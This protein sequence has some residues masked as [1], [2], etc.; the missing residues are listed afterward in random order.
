MVR[1]REASLLSLRLT[2]R[3]RLLRLRHLWVGMSMSFLPSALSHLR[4]PDSSD[5]RVTM[6]A[7]RYHSLPTS[8]LEETLS[9]DRLIQEYASLNN[10]ITISTHNSKCL[11]L[12]WT[13]VHL[14]HSMLR[15]YHISQRFWIPAK[16]IDLH[17][18]LLQMA[19]AGHRSTAL[20]VSD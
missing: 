1:T 9:P 13:T 18:P 17:Q 12:R 7:N 8:L 15:L 4:P 5:R 14:A 6:V 19:S 3:L 10:S 11:G 16:Q 20:S 2:L